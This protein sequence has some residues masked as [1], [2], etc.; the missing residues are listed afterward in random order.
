MHAVLA[1][2]QIHDSTLNPCYPAAREKLTL[3][4]HWY[5][6][7]RLLRQKTSQP[8]QPSERDAVW[9]AASL[10]NLGFFAILEANTPSEAWPLRPPSAFDLSWLNFC[11]GKRLVTQWTDPFRKESHFRDAA[12]EFN[13]HIST[14]ERLISSPEPDWT[15]L[16]DGFYE[17]FELSNVS[18]GS[19]NPYY[20]GAV[21]IAEILRRELCETNFIPHISFPSILDDRIRAL[22]HQK[23]PR[24][25]LLLLYWYAKICNKRLWWLW[26]HSWT[27]GLAICEYLERAWMGQTELTRLLVWPR[28]MLMM[29]S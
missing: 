17:L 19:K 6:A 16:P 20:A 9:I 22:L 8:L 26:K 1:L 5:E 14:L 29:A 11:D 27:E 21:A 24:A 25:M 2:T 28:K 3:S 15:S 23:D 10:I 7:V 13:K 4:Y 12:R 18:G